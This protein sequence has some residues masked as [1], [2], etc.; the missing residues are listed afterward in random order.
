MEFRDVSFHYPNSPKDVLSHISFRVERG[1][2]LAIIGATGSGK[3]TLISLIAR[4]YDATGGQVLVDGADVREYAFDALY[5]RLGYVTQR[6]VLFSGDVESNVRFGQSAG[7]P[8]EEAVY[9]ALDLAQATEFVA[10]LPQG[11]H[12]PIAQGGA[13][14]SGGQKQRLS[15]ARALA[16]QPEILIFDDSFSALD[17]RT[18]ARLRA[19]LARELGDTTRIIVAQR[20]G[21]IRDADQILVLD[22]GKTVG[23]GTHEE[24][25][26]TC[27]VYQEIAR[28]QLSSEELGA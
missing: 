1:Q 7:D 26:K 27:P 21:T 4:F 6:A 9:R 18:D 24:L 13:N 25:M 3:T 10:K 17:Y 15:I 16:R 11:I 14:V 12:A 8:S 23:M 22:E 19:G 5:D 2:T 28:S 20:I